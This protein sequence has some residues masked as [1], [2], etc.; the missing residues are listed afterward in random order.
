MILDYNKYK[1][2]VDT[3]DQM[4]R[5]YTCKQKTRRWSMIV[6]Y[7]IIDI[8]ALNS[9]IIWIHLNPQYADGKS[10]KRRVFLRELAYQLIGKESPELQAS[11]ITVDKGNFG[12]EASIRA[13]PKKRGRCAFCPRKA[14]VKVREKCAKCQKFICPKHF[15]KL[16]YDC[17]N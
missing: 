7:N 11:Q 3:A 2:S 4:L 9:Y 10:H 5:T 12:A 1:G 14:D 16:C 8:T 13:E 15:S 6:F 17:C